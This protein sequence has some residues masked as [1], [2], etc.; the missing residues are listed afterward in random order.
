M[1]KATEYRRTPLRSIPKPIIPKDDKY[2]N[3]RSRATTEYNNRDPSLKF[4]II[5]SEILGNN[6]YF[7]KDQKLKGQ[8]N[9]LI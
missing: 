6:I 1:S 9:Y 7:Q 3:K 8:E 2:N 4:I 5:T